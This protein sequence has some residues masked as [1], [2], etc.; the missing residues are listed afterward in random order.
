MLMLL[1]DNA[2]RANYITNK[3]VCFASKAE[4][5]ERIE[6]D[7]EGERVKIPDNGEIVVHKI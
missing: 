1:S 5:F 7:A 2:A 6:L 4:Y 3:S